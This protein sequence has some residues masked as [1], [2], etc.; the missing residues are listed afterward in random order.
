M[1]PLCGGDFTLTERIR[2]PL[3]HA[4]K[5]FIVIGGT[6]HVGSA[7][8]QALLALGQ[9]V[10]IVTRSPAKGDPWRARG[11]EIAVVDVR[12]VN[13]LRG[14]LRRGRRAFL[15][16]PPAD[17]STDSDAEERAN[18]RCLLEALDG[19]GLEKVVAESTYG[20]RPGEGCGDL[21][22]LHELEEGLRAQPIPAA[23]IRAAYYM[24]N[25]DSALQS[26]RE[27]GVVPTMLPADLKLPMVAP[28]DLGRVA[29]RLLTEPADQIGIHY[30]EGP[31]RYTPAEVAAAFSKALEKPVELDVIPRE[32]WEA[33]FRSLGFSE[34]AARSYA[35]MT[36]ATV[37]GVELPAEPIRGA[38]SLTDYVRRL[39]SGER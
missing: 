6:G 11:A 30:V 24:S 28:Q 33:T 31:E 20:A 13:A 10:T 5:M 19:S 16:N 17:P 39:H 14:V 38:V 25:W 36:A 32:A 12:D 21:T 3:L 7:T 8:A 27:S 22:V 15:L 29:A 26:A 37:D 9:P 1:G 34:A 35:R 4:Q 18:V 23:I 2:L